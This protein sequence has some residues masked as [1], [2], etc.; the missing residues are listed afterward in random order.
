MVEL[1]LFF[2]FLKQITANLSF[3]ILNNQT[4]T[5]IEV[6]TKEA[7]QFKK[8]EP[9]K[10]DENQISAKAVLI[11]E[12]KGPTLYAKNKD[13]VLPIAS[14]TK[15]MT[16]LVSF[17]N[18]SPNEK[19]EIT[20]DFNYYEAQ[21]DF[22]SGEIFNRDDLITSM[23]IS[24]SNASALVLSSKLNRKNFVSLM[25]SY[26]ESLNMK[27]TKF[28]DET[29]LSSKNVSNLNDLYILIEK[30]ISDYPQIANFS[31]NSSFVLKGKIQ[32][33][34]YNTNQLIFRYP[35]NIVLTKTGF[36]DE[37]GKC[38]V[39]VVKFKNSPLVFIGFLNSNDREK[40]AEYLF[41][42]VKNYY[43]KIK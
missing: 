10:I 29:G 7:E 13:L 21:T 17:L 15:L 19:F 1:I 8:I 24:S 30:I 14:I 40:D 31:A 39:M 26:A 37:A 20:K 5:S 3:N 41:N 28:E 43:D 2:E 4:T 6:L 23:L 12:I 9:L 16:A 22:K 25:N 11:K 35:Q 27:N 38:L 32:R 18:Y 36:T 33:I 42:A 34:L